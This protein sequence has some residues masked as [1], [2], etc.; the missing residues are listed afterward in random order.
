MRELAS[1]FNERAVDS[2][3]ALILQRV[4]LLDVMGAALR[5]SMI[6]CGLSWLRGLPLT[7][8]LLLKQFLLL[9]A[10]LG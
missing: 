8:L 2:G 6:G 3:T 7:L 9:C 10:P 4:L 1:F 5:L